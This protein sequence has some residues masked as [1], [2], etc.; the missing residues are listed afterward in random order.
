[1]CGDAPAMYNLTSAVRLAMFILV[2]QN[3][4]PINKG[5]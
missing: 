3:L 4:S 1:M 5:W 2:P